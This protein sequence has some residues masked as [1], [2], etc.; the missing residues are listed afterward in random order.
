MKKLALFA[1]VLALVSCRGDRTAG[2]AGPRIP[3][4]YPQAARGDVVDDHHGTKVADPY[5]WLEDADSAETRQWI[6]AQN[7]VTQQYLAS[8]P[9]RDALRARLTEL[10]NYERYTIPYSRGGRYLFS[11]NDGLQNQ[12]VLYAADGKDSEPRVLID[13]NTLSKD[14][15]VALGG[16][17]LTKDG[18]L[19]AYSLADGGSDWVTFRVRDLATG[20]DRDDKV[21][22]VKFSGAS[23]FEDRGFFYSRFDAPKAGEKLTGSNRFHKLFFHVLGTPQGEDLLIYQRPE[24]GEL[25]VSG[26]VSDDEKFLV[27]GVRKG[28][29]RRNVIAIANL[30]SDRSKLVPEVRELIGGF[31]ASYAFVGNRGS[32]LWFR[33]DKDAPRGRVIAVDAANPDRG[34][35]KTVIP[36]GPD[37]L[38]SVSHV[39]GRLIATYLKDARSLVRVFEADGKLVRDVGLPGIGTAS[40]FDGDP[41]D[42]ETFYSF[43]SFTDP[44]SIWR[45]DVATGRST[46]FR[47]P[48]LQFDPSAFETKQVFYPSKDGTKVPMF[49]THEKGLAPSPDTP[50]LLYA[51]GGFDISLT[52]SFSVTQLVWMERGGIYAVANLRGGGEYGEDWH[53]AGMKDKKQNVFDD[54]I[55]AAEFLIANRHTSSRRLATF[56]GSNGGL[57]IGAT[58]IQR[59]DLFGACMPA[60]GVMDM[61]R[62]H[63][64]TVG[65]GW[66]PEYGTA[67]DPADFRVLHAYSPYHNL[68]PAKYP[69]TLVTTADHDDRVVPA[70]SFKFAAALQHAQQGEAPV[71]IRIDT[72]A[73]H[74]A[75]KPTAK[76]I[77]EAAD[78]LAFL[79]KELGL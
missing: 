45:Y 37:R 29:Q 73:G 50:V 19:L 47:R 38:V 9:Q 40:G 75:G 44:G 28:T 20:K 48:R 77:E 78:R 70:H 32:T 33:T 41:G 13:P 24:D 5:R 52:P 8:I 79:T 39:G 16:M 4:T 22:W 23:W 62:F 31:D 25:N 15:T 12:N 61:L 65:W 53:K 74:G 10:W 2:T 1:A 21:E 30:P 46:V 56:G 11:K 69:P 76:Q 57:L 42:P 14:G 59:P 71:L 43:T 6:D 58:M 67:D 17:S 66:V 27:I 60:V 55:A 7:A 3:L 63:K 34:A 72:R 36:E 35:W 51:Y 26:Q 54:F 68:R 64:F 18:K 49:L